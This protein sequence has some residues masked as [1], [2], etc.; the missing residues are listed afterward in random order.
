MRP[1]T[2]LIGHGHIRLQ[3]IGYIIPAIQSRMVYKK[4][5]GQVIYFIKAGRIFKRLGKHQVNIDMGCADLINST[6]AHFF[7]Q[8]NPDLNRMQLKRPDVAVFVQEK[9]K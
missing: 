7:Q 9:V 1:A 5:V 6:E 8:G 3:F 4:P 2:H